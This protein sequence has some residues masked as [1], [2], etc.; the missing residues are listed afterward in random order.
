MT[1]KTGEWERER[2]RRTCTSVTL[3]AD[4]VSDRIYT[5]IEDL[6]ITF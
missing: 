4:E 1:W 2:E 3:Q 5:G 6:E